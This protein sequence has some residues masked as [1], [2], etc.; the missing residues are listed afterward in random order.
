ME[1]TVEILL[2]PATC[3]MITMALAFM[4]SFKSVIDIKFLITNLLNST[5]AKNALRVLGNEAAGYIF[6]F[7]IFWRVYNCSVKKC[8]LHLAKSLKQECNVCFFERD[9]WWT[10]KRNCSWLDLLEPSAIKF[11]VP[12]RSAESGLQWMTD[13]YHFNIPKIFLWSRK[14]NAHAC[15]FIIMSLTRQLKQEMNWRNRLFEQSI[16]SHDSSLT[17]EECLNINLN[18]AIFTV[19]SQ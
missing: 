6:I 5:E 18:C 11:L 15:R 17:H 8:R 1:L 19:R 2:L 12:G 10:L 9:L 16:C 14:R 4:I 13:D 3:S 7:L